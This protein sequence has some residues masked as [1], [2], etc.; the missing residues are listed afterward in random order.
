MKRRTIAALVLS[1]FLTACGGGDASSE[2]AEAPEPPSNATVVL[3]GDSI[4]QFWTQGI[5]GYPAAEPTIQEHIPGA[6]NVGI[7]G[8]TSDQML[9]RFDADVLSRHPDVV[10]I[11]AGTNDVHLKAGATIDSIATMAERAAA[12]GARVVLGTVPP[13]ALWTARFTVLT[14]AD[15][16]STIRNWNAQLK[17]LAS[18]YG[19]QIADYHTAMLNSDGTPNLSLFMADEVHPNS[20]G[21]AAMWSVLRPVLYRLNVQ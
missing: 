5:P 1:A 7:S 20:A 13:S 10:V 2:I 18:A 21:Y 4:T 19:Y 17:L 12:S 15:T 9:A 3:M 6:I 14:E 8:Q 16:D 11:L